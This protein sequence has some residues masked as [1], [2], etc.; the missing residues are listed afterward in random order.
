MI[1]INRQ[2]SEI[3]K[4][5]KR[6]MV[7]DEA[8]V[9]KHSLMKQDWLCQDFILPIYIYL[10]IYSFLFNFIAIRIYFKAV[11]IFVGD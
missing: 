4:K 2:V 8:T 10:L 9:A 7:G 5:K 3:Q 6:F 11:Y 1:D